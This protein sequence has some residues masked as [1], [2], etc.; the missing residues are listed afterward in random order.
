MNPCPCGRQGD[1]TG[2]CNCTPPE[3]Q[4]YRARISGPLL[5]RIDMH[6]E[7]PHVELGEFE[8]D[9]DR[10]ETTATAALRVNHAREVQLARQGSCNARLTDWQLDRLC[11]PD[12]GGRDLLVRSMKCMGFSARARGRILKLSR[13]IAD[14]DGAET[15][16]ATHVG[17][18]I[19]LRCLDRTTSA[20][21]VDN[22][23]SAT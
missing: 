10:G 16:G 20:T 15:I 21:V 8:I 23:P 17:Q 22:D 11:R 5:D 14:L 2:N 1:P 12:R 18:A 4:R 3:I 9:A 13:T 6:V 7:V 19:M